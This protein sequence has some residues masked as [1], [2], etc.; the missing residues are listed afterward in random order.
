M[1]EAGQVLCK[2]APKLDQMAER[3]YRAPTSGELPQ[4]TQEKPILPDF[5]YFE[6]V[7]SAV[8][9]Q[10]GWI[11]GDVPEYNPQ[12]IFKAERDGQ[13]VPI[14]GSIKLADD[15]FTIFY[16][17]E[18]LHWLSRHRSYESRW[19]LTQ[20]V[21]DEEMSYYPVHTGV[22]M[23]TSRG[24]KSGNWLSEA[25]I[26]ETSQHVLA[27]MDSSFLG[28]DHETAFVD[29]YQQREVGMYYESPKYTRFYGELLQVLVRKIQASRV[30][31][32]ESEQ[33][34]VRFLQYGEFSLD[35]AN[36]YKILRGII[37][38][39]GAEHQPGNFKHFVYL[40]QVYD[41]AF[42]G[43]SQNKNSHTLRQVTLLKDELA[44]FIR[45]GQK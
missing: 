28:T 20:S 10:I 1:L 36:F 31:G 12:Q 41:Q 27:G 25:I 40:S 30:L 38:G 8:A 11:I 15:T 43:Y 26:S 16:P 19:A 44:R 18:Y 33:R 22:I 35:Q 21:L 34:A 42:L 7:T 23:R 29:H 5:R 45:T 32:S 24:Y 37:D 6:S 39:F 4:Y 14:T 17:H 13:Y 3:L 2:T 9:D